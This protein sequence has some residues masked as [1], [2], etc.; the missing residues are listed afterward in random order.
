MRDL[1]ERLERAEAD[2]RRYRWLRDVSVPPHNF[3][4]AVPD[5]FQG[6]RYRPDQV[7]AYIDAAL[8]AKEDDNG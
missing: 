1:I 4:I 3:Y 8:K 2:A 6:V 5:E 7:D